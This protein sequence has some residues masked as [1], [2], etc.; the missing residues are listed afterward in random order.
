MLS[1]KVLMMLTPGTSNLL[2]AKQKF[3][4]RPKNYSVKSHLLNGAPV[5]R[6]CSTN[7]SLNVPGV[8]FKLDISHPVRWTLP[9]KRCSQKAVNVFGKAVAIGFQVLSLEWI[10]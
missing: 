1:L 6:F 4:S 5:F 8:S 7:K 2:F 3:K 10:N 9:S